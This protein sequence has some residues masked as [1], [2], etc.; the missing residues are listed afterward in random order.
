MIRE[1]RIEV[2]KRRAKQ[3]HKDKRVQCSSGSFLHHFTGACKYECNTNITE[4]VK[5]Q[6]ADSGGLQGQWVLVDTHVYMHAPTHPT[7]TPTDT[8]PECAGPVHPAADTV[9]GAIQAKTKN[10]QLAQWTL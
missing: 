2:S 3:G 1:L 7:D 4:A 8:P 6:T 9:R 10:Q 5:G